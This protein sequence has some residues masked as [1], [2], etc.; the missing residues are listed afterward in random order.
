M[1]RDRDRVLVTDGDTRA[2]LAITRSLG[3]RGVSVLVGE[4]RPRSLAS[5]SRYCTRHLTYP[6]PYR[7]PGAF[8]QFLD[9]VVEREAIRALIP[10]TDVT[11]HTVARMQNLLAPRV[12]LAVPEFD[13]FETLTDKSRLLERAAACGIPT[14][15]TRVVEGLA[16]VRAVLDELEYPVVVKSA[17]SRIRTDSGWVATA[18]AY[19]RSAAGL[20]RLY[21][22]RDYLGTFTS[23]VQERIV[24]PGLGV[25]VLLDR[26]TMV[27]AFAHRRLRE[28]PPS[29]GVSVLSESVA[30]DPSLLAQALALLGPLRWHGVAML[31]YKH[32]V[33]TG[34][35]VLIEVN[36]RFWGSVQLAVDAGVDFPLLAHQLALGEA[37]HAADAFS[38][39][40]RSRWLL[41]DLDHLLLRLLGRDR[42][43]LDPALAATSPVREFL[44]FRDPVVQ[45]DVYRRDDPRPMS[46]ELREHVRA[47]AGSAMNAIRAP[48]RRVL[49]RGGRTIARVPVR[50]EMR[51]VR[52]EPSEL[53]GALRRARRLL[54]VCHGNRIR[55]PFAAALLQQSV[56]VTNGVRVV[57]AGLDAIPGTPRHPL[58]VELAGSRRI[59]LS[60]QAACPVTPD[61]VAESDVVFVVDVP[62]LVEFRRRFP[63]AGAKA[64][65]L[66]ALAPAT[67]LD[68]IDPDGGD[69]ARFEA[70]F[71]HIRQATRGLAQALGTSG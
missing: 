42:D 35:T 12:A 23:L 49:A 62:L 44:K 54:V 28:L 65:L 2:A 39:G 59:D 64:F 41:G 56:G 16:G 68:V 67:P 52:R 57:S 66:T 8:E 45:Y 70:C 6:S 4:G 63:A 47:L 7:Q 40:V 1:S 46:Y 61:L 25:F 14:P 10:V 71:D 5:A 15:R 13:A 3:R 43:V 19:A 60:D 17:R 31:E 48:V 34:R 51:R 30:L 33:R 32:D 37:P 36:G 11:T 69:R 29:G 55:S 58:A 9:E 53:V 18:A 21:G 38:V 27:A 20:V 24:G 26:G 50:R 22:Q